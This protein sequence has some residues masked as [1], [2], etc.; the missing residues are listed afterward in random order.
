MGYSRA[1]LTE[2]TFQAITHPEDLDADLALLDQLTRGKIPRYQL[3]K[4]YIRRDGSNVDILLNVSILRGRDDSPLYYIAQIEDVT[5]RKRAEE[6]LRVSET[7]FAGIVSVSADA[8]ISIDDQQRIIIFNAGAEKIFGYSRSE[9]IGAPLYILIPDR[10]R[11]AHRQQV[12]RFASGKE[13]ARPVRTI[14]GLRKSGEEFPADATISKLQVGVKTL[15]TVALRDI[16][17]RKRIEE[18]LRDANA[19]LDAII[20][21]I[22]LMLFIKESTSLQFVRFNRAGEDLLGWPKHTLMGKNDYD[23]W[24]EGQAEFFVERA[25][26]RGGGHAQT[27]L[28]VVFS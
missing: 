21:N 14:T 20:E 2:L 22:P 9:V 8:I 7:Q 19:F 3:E 26:R 1:E 18:Q 13:T 5:A 16:T 12:E 24:P 23:F 10:F 15:L 28:R 27:A 11:D 4:R 25:H 17:E 6:A